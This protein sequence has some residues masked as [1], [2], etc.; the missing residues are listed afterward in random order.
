MHRFCNKCFLGFAKCVINGK[1]YYWDVGGD[2]PRATLTTY[3]KKYPQKN[4]ITTLI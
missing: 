4:Y 1:T 3:F 2:T